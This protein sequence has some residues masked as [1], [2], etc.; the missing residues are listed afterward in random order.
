MGPP[1]TAQAEIESAIIAM[2]L[3]HQTLPATR[4]IILKNKLASV[5][6]IYATYAPAFR[7]PRAI[8]LMPSMHLMLRCGRFLNCPHRQAGVVEWQTQGT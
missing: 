7:R 4:V 1:P 5:A 3:R 8:G 6:I 2:T